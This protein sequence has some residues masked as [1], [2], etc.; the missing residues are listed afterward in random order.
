MMKIIMATVV[1]IAIML[2]IVIMVNNWNN[3]KY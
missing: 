3:K 2:R 1:T